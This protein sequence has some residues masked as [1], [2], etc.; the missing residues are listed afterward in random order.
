MDKDKAEKADKYRPLDR[1]VLRTPTLPFDTIARWAAM[2]TTDERRADLQRLIADPTVREAVYLASPELDAQI[3]AWQKQPESQ[4]GIGVERALVR[5]LSR[6][7]SRSTPF[8]L[9]ASVSVG[10]IGETTNLAIPPRAEAKRHTRLDNDLLFQLCADLAKD[11]GVR[12]HLRYRPNSSLYLA[13][14]RLRY[15][16][17]RL[18]GAARVYHLVAVDRTPYLEALLERARNGAT[19]TEL[20]EVLVADP[21]ITP[22][23]AAAFLDEV[24]DSQILVPEL[25]PA[26][27]GREPTAGIID[28]L[29]AS[30]L[31][32]VADPLA[33]AERA[34]AEIDAAP[35]NEPQRYK[36][37]EQMLAQRLPTKV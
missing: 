22:E 29:R 31:G 34:L 36:A 15:A 27:T 6:M 14:A 23:E 33:D 8:G 24:I 26:V 1:F 18:V 5:Y 7:A 21:E 16:E 28:A 3:P 30:G 35:S 4:A 19:T 11:R 13:A 9:F 10:S 25:A 2:T 17:A 32:L 12:A 37:I 20:V